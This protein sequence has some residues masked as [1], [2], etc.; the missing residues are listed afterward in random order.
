MKRIPPVVFS[1][2]IVKKGE[3]LHD[4]LVRAVMLGQFQAVFLDTLPMRNTMDSFQTQGISLFGFSSYFLE[5]VFHSWVSTAEA[6][7]D[8]DSEA[9]REFAMPSRVVEEK[10]ELL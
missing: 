5:I 10:A 7:V 9:V 6:S 3:Q 4:V 8:K 1:A 2:A